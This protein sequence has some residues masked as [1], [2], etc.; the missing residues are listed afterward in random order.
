MRRGVSVQDFGVG[1]CPHMPGVEGSS[2]SSST[3]SAV[4]KPK[5]AKPF[6]FSFPRPSALAP[7]GGQ[8]FKVGYFCNTWPTR[9]RSC[10]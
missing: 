3:T 1:R 9:S 2:P 5:V 7:F 6:G 8:W 4:V 10:F